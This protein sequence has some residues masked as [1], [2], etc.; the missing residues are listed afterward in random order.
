[1]VLCGPFVGVIYFIIKIHKHQG[2]LVAEPRSTPKLKYLC[3]MSGSFQM[4][5][6]HLLHWENI[7]IRLK[8]E[9]NT[10]IKNKTEQNKHWVWFRDSSF[11]IRL[12]GAPFSGFSISHRLVQCLDMAALGPDASETWTCEH[13]PFP[14]PHVGNARAQP[15]PEL[16]EDAS[17]VKSLRAAPGPPC[18]PMLPEVVKRSGLWKSEFKQSNYF[19]LIS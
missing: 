15:I 14:P 1:M 13:Q 3:Y 10:F 17:L 16:R 5:L 19:L 18:R 6:G 7:K 2:S 4:C 11:C 12:S 8:R 9:T